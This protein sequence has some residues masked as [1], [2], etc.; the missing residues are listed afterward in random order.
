MT[1]EELKERTMTTDLRA[2]A[3]WRPWPWT[4]LH[5]GKG[6]ENR[7]HNR[8]RNYRGWLL[9]H[10]GQ[11]WDRTCYDW[12]DERG[13][14][15]TFKPSAYV[16][17]EYKAMCAMGDQSGYAR[18]AWHPTGIV[19]R[20]RVV[21][22]V[23]P[24]HRDERLP[25][26]VVSPPQDSPWALRIDRPDRVITYEDVNSALDLNIRGHSGERARLVAENL[27][28]RWWQGGH[29]LILADVEALPQAIPCRGRQGIWRVPE[30][31]AAQLPEAWRVG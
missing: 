25:H 22:H 1:D 9:L 6:I 5:L 16:S 4:I 28:L 20:C 15:P 13:L 30:E 19:G 14:I 21:G 8:F 29:G 27:D 17:G 3:L 2:L 12:C 10:A 18:D 11:V 26:L 31:V 7:S 24:W 23:E